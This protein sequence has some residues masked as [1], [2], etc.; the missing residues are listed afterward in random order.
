MIKSL[1]LL[2]ICF[3]TSANFNDAFDNEIRTHNDEE[4]RPDT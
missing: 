3:F 1:G 4:V 2:I